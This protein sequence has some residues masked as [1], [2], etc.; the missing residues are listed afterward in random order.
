MQE[1]GFEDVSETWAMLS[2]P[3]CVKNQLQIT[4]VITQTQSLSPNIVV[5]ICFNAT[6]L[7]DGKLICY[8]MEL[9]PEAFV[10]TLQYCIY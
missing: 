6:Q 2:R 8:S 4:R 7:Y 5:W 1:D 3:Q 10:S 9:Q